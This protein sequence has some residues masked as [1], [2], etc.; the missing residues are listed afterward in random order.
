MI[1]DQI[2]NHDVEDE[3]LALM[4]KYHIPYEYDKNGE[5]YV[6]YGYR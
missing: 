2:I 4:K 3:F 5:V 1:K 6:I